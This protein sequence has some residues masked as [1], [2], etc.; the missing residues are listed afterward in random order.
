[1]KL[2]SI[3]EE[4]AAA[5]RKAFKGVKVDTFVWHC[6]HDKPLERL[7]KR[8]ETRIDYILDFKTKHE[9]S[10]RLRLF[11]PFKGKLSPGLKKVSAAW[12]KASA[13]WE[14]ACDEPTHKK[15][16]KNCPWDGRTI[17]PV[18]AEGD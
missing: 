17:F 8:P 9:Q 13:E 14:K 18:G 15:Q 10:L 7:S 4:E 16:C 2:R 5:Y 11:R 3:Q 6:H 12:D 1:M